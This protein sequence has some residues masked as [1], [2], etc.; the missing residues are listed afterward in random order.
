[1]ETLALIQKLN[2]AD[3]FQ[4]VTAERV[5]CRIMGG[6]C[7][8]PLA[9][10]AETM[11]GEIYLRALLADLDGDTVLHA[12]QTGTNPAELGMEVANDLISQGANEVLH[13]IYRS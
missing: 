12:E 9:V 11:D 2:H 10:F 1:P 13:A 8:S 4:S 5:V 3:T 7:Q 6:G